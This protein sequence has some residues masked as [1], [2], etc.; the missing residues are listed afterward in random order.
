MKRKILKITCILLLLTVT[1]FVAFFVY[2]FQEIRTIKSLKTYEVKDL[3]SL[4][5]YADYEFDD[6]IKVGANDWIEYV[7]YVKKEVA[8]YLP[9]KIDV[10][11]TSCSSFVAHNEK[12]EVLFARNFDHNYSPVVMTTTYPKNGYDMIGACDMGFLKFGKNEEIKAHELNR[13]N[14]MLLCCPYVTT[15]GMNE[16]GLAMSVLDCDFAKISTIENAPTMTVCSMIRVVL[17]NAK[18]VDEAIEIFKSYNISLEKPNHHFMIADATGRSVVMEYTEDGIVAVETPVVTNFDLYDSR[19]RGVG[20][21][22]YEIIEETLKEKNGILSESEALDLLAKTVVT[23]KAQYSTLYNLT[24]G[25]V[26]VF[27]HGDSS[28]VETFELKMV[29]DTMNNVLK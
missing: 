2:Y 13:T 23:G 21:D 26:H 14:A 25:E 19:H 27:T 15:D 6:F 29:E 1:A 28:K 4:K 8:K 12:G 24:T 7:Q 11:G 5:Y 20:Q 22:R 10:S 3:Y 16:Y 18:N 17:E 9:E